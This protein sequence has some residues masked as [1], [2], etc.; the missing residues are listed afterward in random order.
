MASELPVPARHLLDWN[1]VELPAGHGRV[2][3][4]LQRGQARRR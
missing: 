1:I 2:E 3:R 4:H